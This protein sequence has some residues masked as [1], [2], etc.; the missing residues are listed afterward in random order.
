MSSYSE[1]QAAKTI[2][3]IEDEPDI[4]AFLTATILQ[5]TSYHIVLVKD[6]TQ[7]MQVV[8]NIIPHLL[9]LN[10]HLPDMTGIELYDKLHATEALQHVPALMISARLPK[11]ELATRNIVSMEKPFELND[12]LETVDKLLA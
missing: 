8:K 7:A 1:Q 4:G 5:E 3:V 2:L 9:I 11:K 6:A 12:F 10:Y